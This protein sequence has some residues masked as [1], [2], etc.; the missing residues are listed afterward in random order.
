MM[1]SRSTVTTG[2][3][4]FLAS[5]FLASSFFGSSFFGSAGFASSLIFTSS[6]RGA[7]GLFA[8][9]ASVTK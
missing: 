8:S 1:P 3:A 2:G 5:S 6:L 7:I 9:L 4:S